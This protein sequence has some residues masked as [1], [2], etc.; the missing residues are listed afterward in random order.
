MQRDDDAKPAAP[1]PGPSLARP[2]DAG[3]EAAS[4]PESPPAKR[5]FAP[6][7][8]P[9]VAMPKGGGALRGLGETFQVN[10]ATGTASFS[11]PLPIS[12]PG[13][14]LPPALSLGYDGGSGQGPFGAGFSLS[15]PHIA[16]KTDKKI[17]E[18]L[19]RED[20]D[21]FVLSGAEDLV[22]MLDAQ[23]ERRPVL[24]DVAGRGPAHRLPA[25]Q[26]EPIVEGAGHL[27]LQ[28]RQ[29]TEG[30]ESRQHRHDF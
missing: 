17:P 26:A 1:R 25:P 20:S 5:R 14:V 3:R 4:T 19:D 6:I 29:V 8:A 11:L 22:P 13:R 15:A 23:G 12:A 7:S 16:R 24:V 10:A 28:P 18:Y 21:R 2:A 9:S 27:V 30:V